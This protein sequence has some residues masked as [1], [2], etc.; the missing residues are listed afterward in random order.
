MRAIVDFVIAQYCY[1]HTQHIEMHHLY[2]FF[3]VV[4]LHRNSFMHFY[5]SVSLVEILKLSTL[6]KKRK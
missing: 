6:L 5:C 2:K 4:D 1:I 3:P